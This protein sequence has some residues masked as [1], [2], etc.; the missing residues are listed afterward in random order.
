MGDGD[1]SDVASTFSADQLDYVDMERGDKVIYVT[2][3]DGVVR[4][5]CG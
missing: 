5:S 3:G 2:N 4:R 1:G